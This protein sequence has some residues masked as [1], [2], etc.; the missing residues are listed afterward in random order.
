MENCTLISGMEPKDASSDTKSA[1][2]LEHTPLLIKLSMRATLSCIRLLGAMPWRFAICKSGESLSVQQK[3]RTMTSSAGVKLDIDQEI[4][5]LCLPFLHSWVVDWCRTAP[6][7]LRLLG[8]SREFD[9]SCTNKTW[10]HF[11]RLHLTGIVF[12]CDWRL[13]LPVIGEIYLTWFLWNACVCY[14]HL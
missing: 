11:P 6:V 2:S 1:C 7:A 4:N 14:V 10:V 9:S 3:P 5:N 13:W 8:Q 12:G